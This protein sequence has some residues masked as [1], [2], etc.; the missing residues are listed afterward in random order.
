MPESEVIQRAKHAERQ[1][2]ESE[3]IQRAKHAERQKKYR[4]NLKNDPVRYKMYKTNEAKRKKKQRKK[5]KPPE[6]IEHNRTLSRA[7]AQR[8]RDKLKEMEQGN[9]IQE[10]IKPRQTRKELKLKREYNRL[11]K[12]EQRSKMSPQQKRRERQ[13]AREYMQAKRAKPKMITNENMYQSE[14][15]DCQTD[16]VSDCQTDKVLNQT[17]IRQAAFRAK[18]NFPKK[19]EIFA[20]TLK[21]MMDNASPRKQTQ[22]KHLGCGSDLIKKQERLKRY[23]S[24]LREAMRIYLHSKLE[25]WQVLRRRLAQSLSQTTKKYRM[26]KAIS[27]DLGVSRHFLARHSSSTAVDCKR[28]KRCDKISEETSKPIVNFFHTMS[29]PMAE[30]KTVSRKSLQETSILNMPVKKLYNQYKE[31]HPNSKIGLTKFQQLRPKNVFTT[32]RMKHIMCCCEYCENMRYLMK[33]YNQCFPETF[34][35]IYE[36]VNMTVCKNEDSAINKVPLYKCAKRSCN[37]CGVDMLDTIFD[38]NIQTSQNSTAQTNMQLSWMQ[39]KTGKKQYLTKSK[40]VKEI[41]TKVKEM[42]TGTVNEVCENIKKQCQPLALH[43]FL[44]TVQRKFFQET[45]NNPGDALVM[46]SDF[47]ENYTTFYNR[48]IGAAHWAREQITIHP[49]VFFYKCYDCQNPKPVQ[50]NLIC[51]SQDLNHDYHAV[52][53][54]QKE[55]IAHLKQNRNVK[56]SKIEEFSDGCQAQYKSRNTFLDV[57]FSEDDFGVCRRRNF[58]SSNHGKSPCDSA[59]A[60]FKTAMKKAVIWGTTVVNSAED[61]YNFGKTKLAKGAIDPDGNCNHNRRGYLLVNDIS[62]ERN[63]RLATNTIKDIRQVHQVSSISPGVIKVRSCSCSCYKCNNDLETECLLGVELSVLKT[64]NYDIAT[65]LKENTNVKRPRKLLPE[66]LVHDD[67]TEVQDHKSY[68]QKNTKKLTRQKAKPAK[69]KIQKKKSTEKSQSNKRKSEM[70]ELP[71]LH[72][73]KRITRQHINRSSTDL[74]KIVVFKKMSKSKRRLPPTYDAYDIIEVML[75]EQGLVL[76]YMNADGNCFFR[77]ISKCLVGCESRHREIR[78]LIVDFMIQNQHLFDKYI[79]S[80]TNYFSHL[81]EMKRNRTW[82]TSAEIMA[83]ATFLQRE[84]F[85]LT[86]MNNVYQWLLFPPVKMEIKNIKQ[87]CN[88]HLAIINTDGVHYDRAMVQTGGC[89]CGINT[90]VI[91]KPI[92]D[93]IVVESDDQVQDDIPDDVVSDGE[94]RSEASRIFCRID[95]S[96]LYTLLWINP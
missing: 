45:K 72:P 36:V 51:V 12:K 32:K 86:P 93:E 37:E 10:K 75:M 13:K 30:T 21:H 82:A 85:V 70:Q 28:K 69:E 92:A 77:A 14:H 53:L 58:F 61:M 91:I 71:E 80:S 64:L 57:S 34:T 1:K 55:S 87:G 81:S 88:C 40:E 63:N 66:M 31:E 90:P 26:M 25:K 67:A 19:T 33:A 96:R 16:K 62:H 42:E 29:T 38:K 73:E 15:S 44:T 49:I 56:F 9:E 89:N 50:E 74:E 6:Q 2:K 17:C 18:R 52:N 46:V 83:T 39:W 8:N 79:D 60:V 27:I 35:S 5:P 23:V 47:A 54:F 43:L 24:T 20:S 3:V 4:E 95:N 78:T 41:N 84:I 65:P 68:P 7:R 94:D 59:G 22:L 48:E 76:D 11:K